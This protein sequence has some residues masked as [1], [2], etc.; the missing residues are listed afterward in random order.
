ME[1]IIIKKFNIKNKNISNINSMLEIF[2][3]IHNENLK[4]RVENKYF[5]DIFYSSQYEIYII[6]DDKF[7]NLLGYIIFYDSIDFIDLFEIAIEKKM[8]NKG[9]GNRLLKESINLL[10]LEKKY[11]KRNEI[12]KQIILEVDENNYNAIKLYLKLGFEE[13]SLRKNY[14]GLNNHGI[15]MKKKVE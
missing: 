6:L 10:F 1:E 15:V 9:L 8:H 12:E 5:L 14:Y 4:K 7:K 2:V 3:K 13:I 11:K